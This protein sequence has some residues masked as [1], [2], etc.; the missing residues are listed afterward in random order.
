MV[1]TIP[2]LSLKITSAP[3]AY[4]VVVAVVVIISVMVILLFFQGVRGS[5]NKA[6]P[7]LLSSQQT[8]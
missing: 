8:F 5:I 4:R 1:V 3:S 7:P 2:G 6:L